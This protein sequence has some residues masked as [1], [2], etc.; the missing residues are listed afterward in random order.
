MRKL[1]CTHKGGEG[2]GGSAGGLLPHK[3]ALVSG[4][5]ETVIIE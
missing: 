5:R 3:A 2:G 4:K 1:V